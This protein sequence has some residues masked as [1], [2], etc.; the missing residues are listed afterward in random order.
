MLTGARCSIG[1]IKIA[2]RG[3]QC[4]KEQLKFIVNRV[5]VVEVVRFTK[6]ADTGKKPH[7]TKIDM[8]S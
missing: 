7:F 5:L 6:G 3:S 8:M 2:S 1:V 4:L